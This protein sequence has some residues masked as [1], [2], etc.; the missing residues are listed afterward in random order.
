VQCEISYI[1]CSSEKTYVLPV[2]PVSVEE[3]IE[4]TDDFGAGIAFSGARIDGPAPK[5]AILNAHTLAP[6]DDCGRHVNLGVGYHYHALTGC[7]T[8]IKTRVK[9]HAPIVGIAL[10]H[11]LHA[12]FDMNGTEPS[13]LDSCRG[14]TVEGLGYHYH[15]N[16]PAAN[17]ILPCHTAAVGCTLSKSDTSCNAT[18]AVAVSRPPKGDHD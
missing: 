14:H 4:V 11:L 18:T 3:A 10:G 6:F 15:A 1:T 13:D 12:R 2:S 8:E 16:D 17:A 5:D 9:D 7:S